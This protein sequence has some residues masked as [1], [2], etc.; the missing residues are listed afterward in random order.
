M[1]AVTGP[2]EG[3]G[4]QVT[5]ILA[6]E[7]DP[8]STE[9]MEDDQELCAIVKVNRQKKEQKLQRQQRKIH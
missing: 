5:I 4:H 3:G 6:I 8:R 7:V 2:T 9:E 1:A